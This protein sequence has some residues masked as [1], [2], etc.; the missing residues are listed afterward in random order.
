MGKCCIYHQRTESGG[1]KSLLVIEIHSSATVPKFLFRL[2]MLRQ[3]KQVH[4]WV[5]T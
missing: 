5:F 3:Y 1:E 4:N 2:K